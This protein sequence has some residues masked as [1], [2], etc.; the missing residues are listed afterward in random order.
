MKRP[1]LTFLPLLALGLSFQANALLIT[2]DDTSGTN[3]TNVAGT[4]EIDVF[5]LGNDEWKLRL[6]IDNISDQFAYGGRDYSDVRLTGLALDVFGT[7]TDSTSAWESSKKRQTDA[8]VQTDGTATLPGVRSTFDAC[9]FSGPNCGAGGSGG[10]LAS[11]GAMGGSSLIIDG[12][13]FLSAAAFDAA[14]TTEYDQGSLSA[15][16]RFI[17][18]GTNDLSDVA[19]TGREVTVPEPSILAL[20]AAGLVGIGFTRRRRKIQA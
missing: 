8:K 18:I 4:L 1:F 20:M 16:M 7:I 6:T 12:P 19:C 11:S 3:Q 15:C 10:L 2:I 14:L 17:S 5:S 13:S 9:F